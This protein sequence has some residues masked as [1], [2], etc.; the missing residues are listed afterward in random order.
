MGLRNSKP[1]TFRPKGLSDAVDGSNA[2]AGAMQ[3]LAN[4]IPANDTANCWVPRPAAIK[5]SSFAGF[6]TPG[7]VSAA[8]VVG[9]IEYGMVASGANAGK[10]QP[11]AY[12][13][14]TGAFETITGVTAANVPTSPA[15]SGAWTPPIMALIGTRII[16]THPG[17]PGGAVKFGWFDVSN[18]STTVSVT[19]AS[20]S[21]NFTSATNML[22]AG[23]QPGQMITNGGTLIGLSVASIAAD[24]LSGVASGNFTSTG[25]F[26]FGFIGGTPTSPLW[27]AGDTNINNLPAVP[28]SVAQFNGR[29][30][31]AVGN[32]VVFSDSLEPCNVTNASQAIVFGNGLPVTALG[33]L[34]LSS[35]ITGGIVQAIIAFQGISAMQQ[36]TGDPATSNLTVNLLNV[37]TGTLA[38]LSIISTNFGLAFISPDGMRIIEFNGQVSDPIGNHGSGVTVPFI[39]AVQPSRICAAA[40]ADVIRISVQNGFLST[41]PNQEYWF[42]IA[43]KVWSGPHSFP[44]SLIQ[45]WQN[46]FVE[47]PIGLPGTIWRSDAIPSSTTTY[48]ENAVALSFSYQT[49]L[50]PDNQDMAENGMVETAIM[51]ALPSGYNLTISATNETGA[52]LDVASVIITGAVSIWGVFVWGAAAWTGNLTSIRQYRVPWHQPLVFK[53]AYLSLAGA[54]S[55]G[56][57]LGNNYFRIEQLGYLLQ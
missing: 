41:Q 51:A 42:D 38:P 6:T 1:I 16:V 33:A 28:V 22:Q 9:N 46:T 8:L 39:Y 54:S 29:A 40:T 10:D 57:K 26:T 17:F 11:Y 50:M 25:T 45:P 31:Y 27:A 20:G 24:G 35:P 4:L 15:T 32:G 21:P 36:I 55:A 19:I 30:Y 23:L 56:V 5:V 43:L 37:A 44:A 34:P 3:S 12:N 18:F 52:V 14:A 13:L 48:T 2:F 47:H 7:F 49:V 53:Q